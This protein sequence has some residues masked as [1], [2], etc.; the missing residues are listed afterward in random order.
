M[1]GLLDLFP[2]QGGWPL[3]PSSPGQQTGVACHIGEPLHFFFTIFC[4]VTQ[5]LYKVHSAHY[6]KYLILLQSL[7][8]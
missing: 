3:T 2:I 8:K 1:Q 4:N 5:L 7:F 6:L